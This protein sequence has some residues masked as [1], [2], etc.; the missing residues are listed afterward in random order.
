MPPRGSDDKT[1]GRISQKHQNGWGATLHF[2]AAEPSATLGVFGLA[3]ALFT[4]GFVELATANVS[5]EPSFLDFFLETAEG[6]FD[7]F[8]FTNNDLGHAKLKFYD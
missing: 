1:W 2:P 8:V 6:G 4:G 3:L 5:K 7:T